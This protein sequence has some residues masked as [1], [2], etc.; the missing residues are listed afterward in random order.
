MKIGII[1]SGNVAQALAAGFVR[2]GHQVQVGARDASKLSEWTLAPV[3][4]LEQAAEFGELLILAPSFHGAENAIKL[5]NPVHF[6]GKTIID[7]TNPISFENGKLSL[8]IGTTDSAGEQ[9][10]RWLPQ[11]HVVKAFNTV[12]AA[13]MMHPETVGGADMFIAGDHDAAKT[14]VSTL[15]EAFGW[16]VRDLGGIEAS[17]WLEALVMVGIS[18]GMKHQVQHNAFQLKTA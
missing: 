3:V 12:G 18:Y 7:V 17:R 10:Q 11:S 6:A 13:I 4:T 2:T 9:V 5:A 16:N 1:G 8:S 14:Q 15:L